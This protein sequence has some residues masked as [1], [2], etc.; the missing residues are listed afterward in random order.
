MLLLTSVRALIK[1]L[2]DEHVVTWIAA[3]Y[4]AG[5]PNASHKRRTHVMIK[6]IEVTQELKRRQEP[7]VITPADFT[8]EATRDVAG[9]MN[10]IQADVFALYFRPK[11]AT[12]T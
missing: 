7:P 4:F 9:T 10:A 6:S 5:R 2:D 8:A 1:G 11:T 12:G 3:L